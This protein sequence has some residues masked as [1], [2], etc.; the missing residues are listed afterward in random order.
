LNSYYKKIDF[1]KKR[2]KDN[3][4]IRWGIA[5]KNQTEIIGTLGYN[6]IYTNHKGRI[7]YDLQYKHWGKGIMTEVLE[8]IIHYGF[9]KLKLNRIEAEVMQGNI[10]SEKLL[11]KLQFQKEGILKEWMHLNDNF[12]DITIFSLDTTSN[13]LERLS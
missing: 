6:K 9:D 5:P 10:G 13:P 3:I 12:Y 2:F 8:A 1:Y 4:G 11:T 7:G